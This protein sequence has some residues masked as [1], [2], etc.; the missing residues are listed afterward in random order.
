V[1]EDAASGH[2]P[3]GRPERPTEPA[4]V[5]VQAEVRAEARLEQAAKVPEHEVSE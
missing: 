2:T 1:V 4:K 3:Y 5:R